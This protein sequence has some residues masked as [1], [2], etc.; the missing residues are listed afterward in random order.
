MAKK[1]KIML[2]FCGVGAQSANA[3]LAYL[4]ELGVISHKKASALVG[5][6]PFS[7]DSATRLGK[8]RTAGGR[9]ELRQMLYMAVQ[10][11]YRYNPKLKPLYL[12][13]RDRGR[14]HKCA[15]IA[16]LN[17]M[18]KLLTAMLNGDAV[19]GSK[20]RNLNTVAAQ[21]GHLDIVSNAGALGPFAA[22]RAHSAVE[23]K[24]ETNHSSALC[25][26]P[27]NANC[28]NYRITTTVQFACR[29]TRAAVEPKK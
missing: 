15:L 18:I 24:A 11:G 2:S 10:T 1:R 26:K 8:R 19:Y 12:R 16:C 3:I 5:V 21:F 25:S 22:A 14:T 9:T 20:A 23:A 27:S 29:T 13:L 6:A 17:K 28:I 7:N 4:P